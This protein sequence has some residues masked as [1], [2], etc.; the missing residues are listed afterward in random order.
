MSSASPALDTPGSTSQPLRVPILGG[1]LGLTAIAASQEGQAQS[2]SAYP[3][4]WYRYTHRLI[5]FA[6]G[7]VEVIEEKNRQYNSSKRNSTT[8]VPSCRPPMTSS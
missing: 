3:R 2:A 1:G 4:E 8:F 7:A 5:S 6:S